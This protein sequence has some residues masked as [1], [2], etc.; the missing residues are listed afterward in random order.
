MLPYEVRKVLRWLDPRPHGRGF[1]FELRMAWQRATK[2]V[3]SRDTWSFDNY[4]D[5]L[6][7]RALRI[8][9][10]R[11]I[12]NPCLIYDE[13]GSEY[14]CWDVNPYDWEHSDEYDYEYLWP[15]VLTEIIDGFEA[16]DRLYNGYTVDGVF[17]LPYR[18][19]P[20]GIELQAQ[21]DFGMK[22]FVNNYGSLWD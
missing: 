11:D 19:S 18:T 6:I 12:G 14:T 10:D 7:P 13:D 16:R 22:L 2:G 15:A 9:R 4:L 8:L 3:S 21:F 20:E 5:E 17:H 1:V